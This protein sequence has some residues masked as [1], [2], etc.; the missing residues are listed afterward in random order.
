MAKVKKKTVK[1][2]LKTVS[3][4]HKLVWKEI[5][6]I[7][8]DKGNVCYTCGLTC[9]GTNRHIGHGIA[10]SS[11]SLQWK[12]DMRNLKIQC[13]NC[14]IWKGGNQHIF[15]GK[16][17]KEK[18]GLAFLKEACRNVDGIWYPK[19]EEDLSFDSRIFLENLLASL[20][21]L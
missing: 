18:E 4:L 1:K 5:Q 3:Q 2:K 14:N 12:Y 20:K 19:K 17:E 8:K 11:L 10:K 6:R 16:L 21:M 9:Y 7:Y 13:M 15:I